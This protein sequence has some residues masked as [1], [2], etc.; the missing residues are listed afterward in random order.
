MIKLLDLSSCISI[1]SAVVTAI[2][3]TL[4]PFVCGR[5]RH[6]EQL[7]CEFERVS[8]NN[9]FFV[10]LDTIPVTILCASWCPIF[11]K[12]LMREDVH[13]RDNHPDSCTGAVMPA[14]DAEVS[15]F[16]YP[17]SGRAP[18]SV[19]FTITG[20]RGNYRLDFGDGRVVGPAI[21]MEGACRPNYTID[22][23]YTLPGSFIAVLTESANGSQ[24]GSVT[25]RVSER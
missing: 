9:S 18:L 24:V 19:Q 14:N 2:L 7:I 1:V 20:A 11:Q 5:Y 21:C 23:T 12:L 22:H 3:L 4:V 17:T 25:V 6:A 16:A 15:F 10:D 13:G 8:R